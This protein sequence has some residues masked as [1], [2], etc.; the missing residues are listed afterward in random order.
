MSRLSALSPCM[1]LLVAFV[2]VYNDNVYGRNIGPG[3][4]RNIITKTC[5]CDKQ[6][7]LKFFKRNFFDIFLIFAQNIDCGHSLEPP[8]YVLSKNKKKKSKNF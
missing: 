2:I 3:L 6:I 7:F 4:F 5:P 1:V 8:R